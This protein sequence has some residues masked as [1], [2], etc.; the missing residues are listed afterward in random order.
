MPRGATITPEADGTICEEPGCDAE[1]LSDKVNSSVRV[2]EEH[3]DK[4]SHL[5]SLEERR[6]RY[7]ELLDFDDEEGGESE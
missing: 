1:D 4:P 7:T 2:I 6:R 5:E 3:Y